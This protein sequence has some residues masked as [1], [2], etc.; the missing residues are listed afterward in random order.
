MTTASHSAS[1]LSGALIHELE[2]LTLFSVSSTLEGIKIHHEAAAARIAAG[3]SLF[4]K[5]L[6]TQAD[7]GYL[8]PLGVEAAEH[9]HAALQI[10][11]NDS[12]A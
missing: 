6:T 1:Q 10:L 12:E 8:T 5:G 3:E 4:A 7:G 2:L 11:R 9:V